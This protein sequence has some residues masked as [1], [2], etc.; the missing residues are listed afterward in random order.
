MKLVSP[1]ELN[2]E[3]RAVLD[4]YRPLLPD[5]AVCVN[6]MLGAERWDVRPL[7]L[8]GNR[9]CLCRLS[10]ELPEVRCRA[11]TAEL[12]GFSV[13]GACPGR[14][15]M[16]HG[17]KQ[18]LLVRPYV[19]ATLRDQLESGELKGGAHNQELV[20]K[21]FKLL[22][23]MQAC[24][25]IHGRICP[26]NLAL[27]NGTLTILDPMIGA[28]NNTQGASSAPELAPD[29]DVPAS[30]DLYGL[31]VTLQAIVG[32]S[33]SQEQQQIVRRLMLPAPRQRPS[34][35]Q[36]QEAFRHA[37]GV[38]SGA[39]VSAAR[40][41]KRAPERN[42]QHPVS[43][44]AG[45]RSSL[46][47][48]LAFTLVALAGL[49][50]CFKTLLPDVYWRVAERIPFLARETDPELASDWASGDRSRMAGVARL[51]IV[52][53]DRGAESVI[54]DSIMSGENPPNT[55]PRLMRVALND[56]WREQ[57][58]AEDVGA[59]LRLTVAPL[60][61]EG[62]NSMPP[63]SALHPGV[64]LAVAGE[65]PPSDPS[66]QLK[67]LPLSIFERLP[68]P[69][70]SSF[71]QL[72][73]LGVSS[74]GAPESIA[75]AAI[76]SG[77]TRSQAFD[78]FMGSDTSP[79]AAIAR[80]T[81]LMPIVS[82]ND[83]A[84]AQLVASIRDRGGELGQVLGWFDI[85]D[86]AKWSKLSGAQKLSLLLNRLPEGGLSQ[87]Q[88]ADLMTFPLSA[89]RE[90]A[91]L[92]LKKGFFRERDGNLLLTLS[93]PGNRLTREQ[94][95]ALI[96]ALTL[97]SAKRPPF[98]A[99]WFGLKPAP[100]TVLLILLAR[101]A[102]DSTDTFNL[103]AARYLR[104]TQWSATTE[105]LQLMA[106]HPEPLARTLAYSR[107]DPKIDAQKKIL[108]DRISTEKDAGLLKMV[109]GKLSV[110]LKSSAVAPDSGRK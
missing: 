82:G 42:A 48:R 63:L 19:T 52:Q 57:L 8:E 16:A 30:A 71:K 81:I 90:Q 97:D 18:F 10:R 65:M 77:L 6:V 76:T 85:E 96:S 25:L 88:Y 60:F 33:L 5:G 37:A 83:A 72:S 110:E 103:E 47:R 26:S 70:G 11:L 94:T 68:D 105:M 39:T 66:P 91:A 14:V 15:S 29:G 21:L 12:E 64:I 32:S 20:D 35:E 104:R 1:D 89:V 55:T 92:E 2:E 84:T 106:Q 27:I 53:G 61:K 17:A 41:I 51:A 38:S 54:V 3:Q 7:I 36:A 28:I 93:G 86:L 56:L 75:L 100:D 43:L 31:G 50:F 34:L 99:A 95:I 67:V 62:L 45:S 44:P 107:L 78:A 69:F 98:V 87:T 79:K 59:V 49:L 101:S 80:L 102:Y 9:V 23:E 22:R 46:L 58:S 13:I 40:V 4:S 109:T 73:E 24:S 108:Q 74:A